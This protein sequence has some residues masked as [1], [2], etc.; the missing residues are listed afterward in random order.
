MSRIHTA[1]PSWKD[2]LFHIS[3]CTTW[4]LLSSLGF[5]HKKLY[6][7]TFFTQLPFQE[8]TQCIVSF[9]FVSAQNKSL[10]GIINCVQNGVHPNSP[11]SYHDAGGLHEV[12]HRQTDKIAFLELHGLNQARALLGKATTWSDYKQLINA[13]A[14]TLSPSTTRHCGQWL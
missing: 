13:I 3:I 1:V 14:T 10:E 4:W 12:L 5:L 6:D 11:Y 9:L 7:D 8:W 2:T